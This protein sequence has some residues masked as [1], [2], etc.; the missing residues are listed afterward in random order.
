V[1]DAGFSVGAEGFYGSN[2]HDTDGEKTNLYGG[3]AVVGMTFGEED[4]IAPAVYG[5][6]G[7]MTHSFK[8]D[9][10]PAT[11]GSD[12]SL[13]AGFGAGVGIPLG[14]IGVFVGGSFVTG[15]SDNS[16][17]KYIGIGASAMIPI[18]G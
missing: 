14:S 5:G 1:G 17:T 12:T 2:N 6:L 13:A 3:V 11:E 18:G 16:G 4:A 7:F 8:S 9:P 15:F 10:A